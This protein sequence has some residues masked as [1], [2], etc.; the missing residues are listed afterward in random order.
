MTEQELKILFKKKQKG[1]LTNAEESMLS[2]FEKKM[3]ERNHKII[4]LNDK[5][6]A[7]IR[8]DIY[9]KI[10]QPNLKTAYKKWIK[11]AAVIIITLTIGGLSLNF[12]TGTHKI[13][14]IKVK[15]AKL[16]KEAP[17]GKKLTFT[18]PDGSKVKLNSGSKIE[19]PE[20]F[21]DSL[22]EVLL[23]GEAFFDVKKDLTH[24][25]IVKTAYVSTHVLGTSFN[26]KA[27]DDENDIAVTL[28]TGKVR[29]NW[30]E[31]DTLVLAPSDQARFNKSTKSITK[32]KIDVDQFL[33]WKDGILRF[34]D[35]KLETALPK[36]EKWFNVK[37]KLLN[38]KS[39]K[40]A[41]TGIFKDASLQ[42]ILENITF[43]KPT[44]NFQFTSANEVEIS[45]YCTN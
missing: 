28:A 26:I 25:F 10:D 40:C 5:H 16:T 34:D 27:Y 12:S 31:K 14:Q 35:E 45:G 21:N 29:I 17:F 11:I 4:F 7:K 19:Y 39:A 36:L 1:L 2:S 8:H 43:V 24:P 32:Q 37:I 41:F 9:P 44:L 30:N 3:I 13:K 23:S 6:S 38:K 42:R 18:L 33:G 20:Q 15:I 22:R